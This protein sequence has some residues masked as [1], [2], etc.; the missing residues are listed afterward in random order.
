M[1]DLIESCFNREIEDNIFADIYEGRH[2]QCSIGVIYLTILN[3]PCHI[4]FCEENTF[5][6]RIIPGSHGPDAGQIIKSPNYPIGRIYHTALIMISCNTSAVRKGC[7]RCDHTY[8]MIQNNNTGHWKPNFGNFN[9]DLPQRS[10][11]KHQNIAYNFKKSNSTIHNQ[12]FAEH[13][14]FRDQ[15]LISIYDLKRIQS[16]IDN[17]SPPLD[18]DRIPLK[19][20]SRF[21]G[22]TADQWKSWCLIYSTL[23]QTIIS[24]KKIE[25]G[26]L[27]I[28]D[29]LYKLENVWGSKIATPNM[30][31]HLYIKDC[32]LDYGP[33]IV[34]GIFPLKDLTGKNKR[35]MA[36]YN[37]TIQEAFTYIRND[38]TGCELIPGE[39]LASIYE[40]IADKLLIDC[41]VRYY[42]RIYA[43]IRYIFYSGV[44]RQNNNS[45]FVSSIIIHAS[46]FHIADERFGSQL[47]RSELAA[48]IMVTFLDENDYIEY[49]PATIRYFFKHSILLPEGHAEHILAFVDWYGKYN[50]KDYFNI[51]R[52]KILDEAVQNGMKHVEL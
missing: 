37:F 13:S 34:F 1:E 28:K 22:F 17:T 43:N 25:D 8:P 6:V 3:L 32:L 36:R 27:A 9:T 50:K 20:A 45:I 5:V 52:C 21:A 29:F 30:H 47:C 31:M 26:D 19:I 2:I 48:N 46:A 11:E 12:I 39:F 40:M 33:S 38:S 35:I 24:C 23:E 44:E 16:I 15:L 10:R 49:W 41:L 7:Y 51:L 14:T 42:E 4:Q 18:I